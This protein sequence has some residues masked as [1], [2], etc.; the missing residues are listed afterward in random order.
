MS[1][2]IIPLN[3]EQRALAA[4][5]TATIRL[6]DI[7]QRA[8]TLLDGASPHAGTR[9]RKNARLLVYEDRAEDLRALLDLP[10]LDAEQAIAWWEKKHNA[11]GDIAQLRIDARRLAVAV[12]NLEKISGVEGGPDEPAIDKIEGMAAALIEIARSQDHT[13][14]QLRKQ[15]A[16]LEN[17]D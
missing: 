2:P 11:L 4:W 10:R 14:K 3:P 15:L 1:E 5:C 6:Q 13:I 12:K 17:K 9:G 7:I 8:R 16:A